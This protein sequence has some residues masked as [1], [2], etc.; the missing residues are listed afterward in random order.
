MLFSP[1]EKRSLECFGEFLKASHVLIGGP[2]IWTQFLWSMFFPLGFANIRICSN[3]DYKRHKTSQLLFSYCDKKNIVVPVWLVRR[4]SPEAF[5]LWAWGLVNIS[6]QEIVHSLVKQG[7]GCRCQQVG[8][9][10]SSIT[11][12]CH[13]K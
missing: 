12:S 7:H 6:Y 13:I 11:P 5:R 1:F 9:E 4:L 8:T 2:R 3:K 10:K